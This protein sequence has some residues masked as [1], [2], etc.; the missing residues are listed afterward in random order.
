MSI[1]NNLSNHDFNIVL[2]GWY[3]SYRQVKDFNGI[4]LPWISYWKLYKDNRVIVAFKTKTDS[5]K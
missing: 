1:P 2:D 3:L 4:G 5:T